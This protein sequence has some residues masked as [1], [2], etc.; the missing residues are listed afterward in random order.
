M[1]QE[2]PLVSII[3]TD[4]NYGRYIAESIESA[5][6]QT[7]PATEIIIIN[8]GSTDSSDA[9]IQKYCRENHGITY[10]KQENRGIVATRN[11]GLES[12]RGEYLCFLDADD[13]WDNNYLATLVSHAERDH[14]DVV[15][16]DLHTFGDNEAVFTMPEFDLNFLIGRNFVHMGSLIRRSVIG[17]HRFDEHLNGLGREDWDFFLG[18]ALEGVK[19]AKDHDAYLRYRKH[20]ESRDVSYGEGGELE[21]QSRANALR[22]LTTYVY[23]IEKYHRL[24]PQQVTYTTDSEIVETLSSRQKLQAAFDKATVDITGLNDEIRSL[25]EDNAVK[26]GMIN[27]LLEDA[28]GLNEQLAQTSREAIGLRNSKSF[29]VG[30]LI[31]SPFTLARTIRHIG[32]RA[33]LSKI[34]HVVAHRNNVAPVFPQNAA[35]EA[36]KYVGYVAANYPNADHIAAMKKTVFAERPL[37]SVIMP[38]YNTQGR[39]LRE[40]I[41]SV[42]GQAYSNWELIIVDD[43]SSQPQVQTIAEEYTA[44]DSRITFIRMPQNGGIAKATN[45]GIEAANGEF[46]ALFDHD[47]LLWPNALHEVVYII[48]TVPGVNFL[49]TD[50]DKV[51]EHS[52]QHFEP[53]FKPDW[54]SELLRSVNYITHFTV[55]R[56]SVLQQ[57]GLEDPEYNG[58]QD[59]ELFLR[60]TRSI[61][62]STICHISK[63]LYSWRAYS[64]STARSMGAKPYALLAQKKAVETDLQQR[65]IAGMVR[66]DANG[67]LSV[68]YPLQGN[69]LISI[70]IPSK[71]QFVVV[72]RCVE[73]IYERSTYKNFEII[74][75][76]TGSDDPQVLDW[77]RQTSTKHSNFRQ[78]SFVEE[79]FS[80]SRSCNFGTS[81]A[82]GELIIQLNNDT[83]VIS[84]D[85][86]QILG[87]LA[88]QPEIGAVGPLLLYPGNTIIQHAGIGVGVGSKNGAA[89]NLF[90]HVEKNSNQLN[91]TQQ[92][93]LRLIRDVTAVTGACMVIEKKKFEEVGGFADEFRVTFNDVDLCLKLWSRGYRNVYVPVVELTHHESIS[94]G[95]PD[96]SNRDIIELL[97]A[98]A[99]FKHRWTQFVEADPNYN[100]NLSREKSDFTL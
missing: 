21:T 85:W 74:L 32:V 88:Q 75:V 15:Y 4:Y 78:L 53:F 33:T 63:V 36:Q 12:A 9:V 2:C 73:S 97:H 48:N 31:A 76:D 25:K 64:A 24:Y 62:P 100:R 8:D 7:Y 55:I 14:L 28:A 16:T 29:R 84:P 89:A 41:D 61:R 5:L 60:V 93:M 87:G 91:V 20:G 52:D 49:Y 38:A 1:I 30:R 66:Q 67:W 42:I 58:A 57:T 47:D 96:R 34:K 83:E 6:S 27:R 82:N 59:W 92:V 22:F 51:N 39:Y 46:I 11:R 80:Y 65:N 50:E 98:D 94:V 35:V 17:Q 26:D 13:V 44:K 54:N 10:I 68:Q 95:T 99:L 77:Y 56:A 79:R 72:K 19:F 37:I 86:M 40:A 23:I 81:N 43:A 69:P 90:N 45:A 71:N 70:V 3:I 18:L